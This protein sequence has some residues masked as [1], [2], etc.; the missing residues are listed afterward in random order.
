MLLLTV[1]DKP[2]VDRRQVTVH[3]R[4]RGPQFMGHHIHELGLDL[5]HAF[6]VGNIPEDRNGA[7]EPAGSEINHRGHICQNPAFF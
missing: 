4:Q 7:Q 6:H 5:F 2:A 1:M 3:G